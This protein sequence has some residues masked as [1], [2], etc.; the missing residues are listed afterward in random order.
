MAKTKRLPSRRVIFTVLV[1]VIVLVVVALGVGGEKT[2]SVASNLLENARMSVGFVFPDADGDG[3]SD[4]KERLFGTNPNNPDSDRNGVS[5][6]VQYASRKTL[7]NKEVSDSALNYLGA[8]G[9]ALANGGSLPITGLPEPRF[10]Q[11][12]NLYFAESLEIVPSTQEA[13]NKY[14][15]ALSSVLAVQYGEVYESEVM[16]AVSEWVETGDSNALAAIKRREKNLRF[17]AADLSLLTIPTDIVDLHLDLINNFYKE[18][19]SLKEIL[20][21]TVENPAQGLL[22]GSSYVNYRSKRA[23]SIV[24]IAE[25]INRDSN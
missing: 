17:A 6:G 20:I 1:A 10:T 18:S 9:A 23:Q 15:F 5:D 8:T 2:S 19:L 4:W 14:V 25:Y 22:A 11:K 24:A 13:R 3:L 21:T 7:P 16:D 12:E